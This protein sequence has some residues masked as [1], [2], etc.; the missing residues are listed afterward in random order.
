MEDL[1][2]SFFFI[3]QNSSNLD[4]LKNSIGKRFLEGFGRFIRI[5]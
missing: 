2:F 5:I 4:E 3:I 1:V